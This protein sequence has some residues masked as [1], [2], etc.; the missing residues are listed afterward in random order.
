M[1][2]SLSKLAFQGVA[3]VLTVVAITNLGTTS[4]FMMYQPEPPQNH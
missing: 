4:L 3:A 2:R 1:W